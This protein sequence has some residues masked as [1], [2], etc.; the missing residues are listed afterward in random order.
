MHDHQGCAGSGGAEVSG[1]ASASPLRQELDPSTLTG[2]I[3]GSSFV[4]SSKGRRI[5]EIFTHG[6]ESQT[7]RFRNGS[8]PAARMATG[9]SRTS[10]SPPIDRSGGTGVRGRL[11]LRSYIYGSVSLLAISMAEKNLGAARL[12][13]VLLC[14]R[15]HGFDGGTTTFRAYQEVSSP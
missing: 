3:R 14:R 7:R 11:Q 13:C 6:H 8:A 2:E 10:R 1:P 15:P 12:A 9:A 4:T 5:E